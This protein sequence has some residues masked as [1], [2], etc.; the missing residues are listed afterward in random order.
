MIEDRKLKL[1]PKLET[2]ATLCDG[3]KV[4]RPFYLQLERA[5]NVLTI[6]VDF[7][8]GQYFFINLR[9]VKKDVSV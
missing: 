2:P 1:N 7:V 5:W 3:L 8:H 6:A 4:R 9:M